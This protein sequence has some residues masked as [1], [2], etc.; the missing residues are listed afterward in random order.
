M[1]LDLPV[2]VSHRGLTVQGF[3]SRM[4]ALAAVLVAHLL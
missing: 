1:R 2:A 4:T 3:D